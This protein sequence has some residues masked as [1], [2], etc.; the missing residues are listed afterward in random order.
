M[1]LKEGFNIGGFFTFECLDSEGHVKWSDETKNL[2]VTTGLQEAIDSTLLGGTPDTSW[3]V[4]LSDSSSTYA[5][6]DTLASHSGWTEFDEYTGDRQ[7]WVGVRSA[8]TATNTASVAVF[9]ITGAGGG[10]GGAFL[11]G[12][13]TGTSDVLF[14]GSA[15]TADRTV[16]SGDTVNI[17]YTVTAA[18]S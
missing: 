15:L 12:G 16:A 10:V 1:Q 18:A 5:A 3:F 8:Q 2:V 13:A 14:S 11:C 6:A 7:S 4:G 9:P 17:T